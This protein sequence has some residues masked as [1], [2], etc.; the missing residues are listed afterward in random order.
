MNLKHAAYNADD[1]HKGSNS[2]WPFIRSQRGAP[3]IIRMD[4]VY[5]CER[6]IGPRSY[7]L[8]IRYKGF[9]LKAC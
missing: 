4:Y 7:W 8:C 6:K 1:R 5:R 3:L 9:N 2:C